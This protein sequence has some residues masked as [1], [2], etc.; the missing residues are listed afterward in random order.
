MQTTYG[1]KSHQQRSRQDRQE[2]RAVRQIR[3]LLLCLVVFAMVFVGEGIW[4]EQTARAGGKVLQVLRADMDVRGLLMD[5]GGILTEKEDALGELGRLCV[6]AFAPQIKQSEIRADVPEQPIYRPM[7]EREHVG[8]SVQKEKEP[9][10]PAMEVGAVVQEVAYDGPAL[11]GG[12]SM[13][14]LNLGQM[15]TATPVFGAVTSRF[16]YR[17]HPVLDRDSFHPGVDIGAQEGTRICAF[18]DG[19][20][21]EVGENEDHGRF[22]RLQHENGVETLYAHCSRVTVEAGAEVCVGQQ[23]ALVGSTG[24]STGAHLHFEVKLNGVGLDPLRYIDP[25]GNEIALG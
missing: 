19:M 14:W 6:E 23:I 17:E 5:L 3:Q 20:A 11:P 8:V 1:R 12:Y 16:G 21:A 7:W 10:V 15:L 25:E 4:P 18:A 13:Q 9:E 24:R 2:R 22:V